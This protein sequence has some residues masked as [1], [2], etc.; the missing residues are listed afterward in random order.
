[1]EGM[2]NVIR[3][4]TPW[5]PVL[6][7]AAYFTYLALTWNRHLTFQQQ[8]RDDMNAKLDEYLK[9]PRDNDQPG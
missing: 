6:V 1:M 7:V 8:V 3:K 9:L 5:L 4:V 2:E